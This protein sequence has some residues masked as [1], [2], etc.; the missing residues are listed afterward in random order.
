MLQ[1]RRLDS[2]RRAGWRRPKSKCPP[3]HQ[4]W[5]CEARCEC[6]WGLSSCRSSELSPGVVT[7][8]DRG[9][10]MEDGRQMMTLAETSWSSMPVWTPPTRQAFLSLLKCNMV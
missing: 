9:E 3:L 1:H 7:D 4:S 8:R 5:V 10:T 2:A 6:R